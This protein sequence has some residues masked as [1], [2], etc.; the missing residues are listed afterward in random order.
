MPTLYILAVGQGSS[1]VLVDTEG[2]SII[3]AGPG[4][5]LLEFLREKHIPVIDVLILTHSD[6]DHVGGVMALLTSKKV[7]VKNVYLNTDSIKGTKT[8][9]DLAYSLLDYQ[10][11]REINL[12]P[13]VS[14]HLNGKLN[15]GE[16]TVEILAPNQYIALKG[17][18]STDRKGRTLTSNSV[19]AVVRL[20][21]R[22]PVAILPGDL[23]EV[24][25]ENLLEHCKDAKAW[26][27][28]FPHHG[29]A[30]N[31]VQ[32][33]VVV[34]SVGDNAAAFPN[35]KVIETVDATLSGVRMLTTGSSQTL[36]AY[37]GSKGNCGHH[38]C[39]GNISISIDK[40]P[41][42]VRY[43]DGCPI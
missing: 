12:E 35:P 1:S 19:S 28:V 21:H 8:F 3:D 23:D 42:E 27:T 40:E 4:S 2:V 7:E 20:V 26:L 30:P 6:K 13:S 41:L 33:Q 5:A 22:Q 29:G 39:V 36:A 31:C 43:G 18:G 17:P 24:G 16:V 34:F 15:R 14:P 9:D 25:L 37:V 32:P 10:E 38:D 11:S